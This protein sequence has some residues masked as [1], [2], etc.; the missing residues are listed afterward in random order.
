MKITPGLYRHFK[1]GLYEILGTAR[2][3]ENEDEELLVVYRS[4]ATNDMW[5][6]PVSKFTN[7]VFVD[8]FEVNRF[9]KEK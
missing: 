9:T 2:N 4:V 1:G 5:V 8:G 7:K 6:R 3:S